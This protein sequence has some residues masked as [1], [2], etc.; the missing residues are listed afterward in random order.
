M[1]IFENIPSQQGIEEVKLE[2]GDSTPSKMI[3]TG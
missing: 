2:S 1:I 3:E